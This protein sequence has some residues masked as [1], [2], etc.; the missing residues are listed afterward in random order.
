[1]EYGIAVYLRDLSAR[2]TDVARGCP[3]AQTQEAI[4]TLCFELADK[5]H[6]IETNFTIP[7]RRRSNR[8][9]EEMLTGD[10]AGIIANSARR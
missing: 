1:M 3:D 6:V 4:V 8:V 7:V 5:A 2:L 10:T 9:A